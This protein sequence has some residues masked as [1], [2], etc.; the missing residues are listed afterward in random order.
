MNDE[1][2]RAGHKRTQKVSTVIS[3]QAN[4]PAGRFRNRV[5]LGS[6]ARMQSACRDRSRHHVFQACHFLG[7]DPAGGFPSPP[8]AYRRGRR[9]QNLSRS[10][11]S[12]AREGLTFTSL[13]TMA[14]F[15]RRV[16]FP[17]VKHCGDRMQAQLRRVTIGDD[18]HC[19]RRLLVCEVRSSSVQRQGPKPEWAETRPSR[20]SGALLQRRRA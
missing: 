4:H 9:A 5:G 13:S 20:G 16:E 11:T 6:R 10:R 3:T 7:Y 17:F 19:H 2:Q 18:H 8:T 12:R 14:G 15:E 1:A